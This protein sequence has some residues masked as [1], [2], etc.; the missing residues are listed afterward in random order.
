MIYY[1]KGTLAM[2]L[3]GKLVIEASGL[4]F[5]VFV[6]DSSRLLR[7]EE[8]AQIQVF[9][10]MMVKEDGISL[11]GFPDTAS[12]AMF[13]KLLA[14]S[15]VGAKAAVSL[16]AAM[17]PQELSEAIVFGDA[18]MLSRANGIG[19]KTA[20]RIILELK[21]KVDILSPAAAQAQASAGG[22]LDGGSPRGDAVEALTG[23]GYSRTE[24]A[25]AVASVQGEGLAAEEYIRLAL[26]AMAPKTH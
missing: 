7:E 1:I 17:S 5:E 25:L 4:G 11:Y 12:L 8:G 9:T 15:G 14:V 19:K 18:A 24:A 6:P 3:E 10:A 16:L 22:A 26:K 20:E 2:K 13:H 21:D 23:L